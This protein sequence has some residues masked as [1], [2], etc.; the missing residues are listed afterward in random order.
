VFFSSIPVT[1]KGIP[2]TP[3]GGADSTPGAAVQNRVDANGEIFVYFM[4]KFIKTPLME[5]I[6]SCSH[7][8]TFL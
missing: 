4:A 5:E 7:P 6:I 8:S 1:H 3:V 2:R